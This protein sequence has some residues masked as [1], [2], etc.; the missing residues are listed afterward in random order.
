[1]TGTSRIT[2]GLQTVAASTGS[3][4]GNARD[5]AESSVML[6]RVADD[7]NQLIREFRY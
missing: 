3:V 2:D 7:L 1:M 4:T 6:T 5:A